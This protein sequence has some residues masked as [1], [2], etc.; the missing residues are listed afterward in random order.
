LGESPG[1]PQK[2]ETRARRAWFSKMVAMN[3]HDETRLES[4]DRWLMQTLALVAVL[5]AAAL[6]F[7]ALILVFAQCLGWLKSGQW[8]TL[9]LYAVFLSQESQDIALRMYETG[10]QPLDLVPALGSSD[11]LTQV[12]GSFAGDMI[13]LRKVVEWLLD[14]P[15][16]A[17][18]V[19]AA[20]LL[21]A[22]QGWALDAQMK[23]Q[24]RV[25]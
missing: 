18:L 23:V 5:V 11:S 7:W 14:L 3:R 8:Q 16:T 4:F 2:C 25:N 24:S 21:V 1:Q 20:F 12:A 15:F 13:G 10:I 9:P 19:G 17:W 6:F 22:V